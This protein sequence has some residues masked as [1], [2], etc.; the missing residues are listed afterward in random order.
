MPKDESRHD[1]PRPGAVEDAEN[2]AIEI[3][4][5][6]EEDLEETMRQ[7]LA[8]V[9]DAEREGEGDDATLDVDRMEREIAD[10]R[11]LSARTLADFDNYRKRSE[12]ERQE[13]RRYA[14]ME[15]LRD[16]LDVVDNLERAVSA[17]GSAEDLKQGV[18]MTL[19]QLGD[20][21]RRHGVQPVEAEG[22][23]F[24]PKVHDAVSRQETPDVEEPTVASE[25][26]KGY[27]L[28][29]RLVRPAR[30]VVAV[31]AEAEEEEGES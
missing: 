23:T 31:P 5:D 9:E 4:G 24:D 22:R 13:I 25:L 30:V 27:T 26:Q 19:R 12:R 2:D 28:H 8:A 6:D 17:A 11:D 15:P 21:L 3:D 14:L 1:D 20:V 7:A 10:L 18:E 16:L 29:D